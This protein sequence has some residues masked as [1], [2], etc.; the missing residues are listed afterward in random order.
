MRAPRI[1]AIH[2]QFQLDNHDNERRFL[3]D[4]QQSQAVMVAIAKEIDDFIKDELSWMTNH[5]WK[6]RLLETARA[7]QI[8]IELTEPN[9]YDLD[10]TKED[11]VEAL[12]P[13][14]LAFFEFYRA[15]QMILTAVHEAGHAVVHRRV[16]PLRS[17]PEQY[18]FFDD[19][20]PDIRVWGAF[21]D[22]PSPSGH[23]PKQNDTHRQTRRCGDYQKVL[24]QIDNPFDLIPEVAVCLA[25]SY[26]EPQLSVTVW[27]QYPITTRL[28]MGSELASSDGRD[29]DMVRER[30]HELIGKHGLTTEVTW[31]EI[32][33][34]GYDSAVLKVQKPVIHRL[35]DAL[36]Q[37]ED[38]V[39]YQPAMIAI[40]DPLMIEL[41]LLDPASVESM[42][43]VTVETVEW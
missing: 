41:G 10:R 22:T 15:F 35:A 34:R 38:G 39:M 20:L 43:D 19:R 26:N 6:H 33:R 23:R 30:F 14:R 9:V 3:D 42:L 11:C 12:E 31:D 25:G 8:A 5:F 36:L 24:S 4:M 37:T 2:R 13:A 7:F 17:S 28:S 40:I 1:K 27:H 29:V 21:E 16:Y 32:W 18:L